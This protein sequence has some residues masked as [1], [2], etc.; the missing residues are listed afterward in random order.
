M[1]S[2]TP[3]ISTLSTSSLKLTWK[4]EPNATSYRIDRRK[5][6]DGTAY[7]TI[8]TTKDT[9]YIDTGLEENTKYWY[10]VYAIS[11]SDRSS[12]KNSVSGTTD[13]AVTNCNIKLYDNGQCLSESLVKSG[14]KLDEFLLPTMSKNGY[15]F[16]G[17]YTAKSGGTM[18][19]I[20]SIVPNAKELSL[21]AHWTKVEIKG[22]LNSDNVLTMTD[23]VL[24]Q[25]HL[26]N[27]KSL[28]D[29][30][31][32]LADINNDS[33]VNIFDLSLLKANLK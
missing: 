6:G 14:T 8:A 18:Y 15:K 22:D 27:L 33:R 21:Y 28:S 19:P 24:L 25:K 11:G 7:E 5:S 13:K 1:T 10:R 26:L 16:E 20:G 23:A 2:P 3:T 30:Q 12:E 9:K 29:K 17:W 32:K 4:A 31:L